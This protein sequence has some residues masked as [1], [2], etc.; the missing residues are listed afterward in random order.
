[1]MIVVFNNELNLLG[2][3]YPGMKLVRISENR[4]F[5]PLTHR[6]EIVG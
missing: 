6:W 1:M 5:M 2:F 4:I 3:I